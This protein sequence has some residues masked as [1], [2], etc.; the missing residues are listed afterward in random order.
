MKYVSNGN[1]NWTLKQIFEKYEKLNHNY[2][3]GYGVFVVEDKY[4][5]KIMKIIIILQ[6]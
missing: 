4:S 2:I 1:Y 5:G 6:Y 3:F